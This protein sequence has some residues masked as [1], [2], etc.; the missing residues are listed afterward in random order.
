M[1]GFDF[2][3]IFL[4]FLYVW[5]IYDRIKKLD[6]KIEGIRQYLFMKNDNNNNE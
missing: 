3:F 5:K 1:S 2:L 6:E 4:I